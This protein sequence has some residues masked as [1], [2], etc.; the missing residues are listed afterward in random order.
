VPP[1]LKSP[2]PS[3]PSQGLPVPSLQADFLVGGPAG[4][5]PRPGTMP[6]LYVYEHDGDYYQYGGPLDTG[7]DPQ[8]TAVYADPTDSPLSEPLASNLSGAQ[9]Y[10]FFPQSLAAAAAPQHYV[11]VRHVDGTVAR[12]DRFTAYLPNNPHSARRVFRL[13]RLVDPFDNVATFT[14]DALNRLTRIDFPSGLSQR[15]NWAPNWPGF[16]PGNQLEITYA[17]GVVSSPE[18]AARRPRSRA[19]SSTSGRLRRAGWGR[20]MS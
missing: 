17:Q 3:D 7:A 10:R 8:T 18:L 2:D 12:F 5:Q 20:P 15:W 16:V 14:Y 1:H 11:E 4:L 19:R 9:L 13:T 6:G